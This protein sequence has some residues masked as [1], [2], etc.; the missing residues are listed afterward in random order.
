MEVPLGRA[1]FVLDPCLVVLIHVR[2]VILYLTCICIQN[3]IFNSP[4]RA[5]PVV[6]YYVMDFL[7]A[8]FPLATAAL[9][10]DFPESM[11]T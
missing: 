9:D 7:R 6:A 8:L 1:C 3:I 5:T 11:Q 10:P 4:K 2:C